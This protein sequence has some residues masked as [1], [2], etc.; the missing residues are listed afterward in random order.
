MS[1]FKTKDYSKPERVKTVYGGGKNSQKKN[2]TKSIRNIFKIKKG[3]EAIIDGI[4]RD[5]A[6][7][8]KQQEE[9]DYY[10]PR[11]IGSFWNNNYIQYESRGDRNESLSV[12][13]YLDKVKLFLRDII[14]NLQIPDTWKIQLTIAINFASSKDVD[15]EHVMYSKCQNVE[16][17]P[18]DNANEVVSELFEYLSFKI[19]I[20]LE[21]SMKESDLF[22]IQCN[23]VL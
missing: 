20:G 1:L 22:S 15:E 7:I 21:K 3:N 17:I 18:Y 5:V 2:I 10:K 23:V 8:F 11:R 4:I 14:I 6:T 13:E 9:K 12:K 16:F 19:P